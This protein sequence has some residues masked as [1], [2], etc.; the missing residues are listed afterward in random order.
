MS[1]R[2]YPMP[3]GMTPQQYGAMQI[4]PYDYVPNGLGYPE[5][6]RDSLFDPIKLLFVILRYRWLLVFA[7]LAA[8][9]GGF[10]VTMMQTPIYQA[11]ARL[12]VVSPS[13]RIFEDIELVSEAADQRA[14]LTAREKILTRALAERVVFQLG[15]TERPDF[16][17]PSPSF[18]PWNLLNRAFG[19]KDT[20][21]LDDHDAERR[22]NIAIARVLGAMSVSLIP[23]TSLLT[24]SFKDQS[25][26]YARDIANQI[27]Q[28]FIDQRVDQTGETS[29]LA[30]QFIQEQVLQVK[31]K[32]QDSEQALVD[33]AR[34]A[35]ITVTGGES[36]L[37]SSN[38][39]AI[40]TALAKAIEERLSSDLLV[41]QIDLGRGDSLEQVLGSDPLQKLR[42]EIVSLTA[43]YQQ[44]L[45][46]F[47]PGFPEMQQLQTR[48]REL[49]RQYTNGVA[50]IHDGIRM[51]REEAIGREAEL[52]TKLAEL[53]RAQ[54]EY[55]DK[56]IQYTILKRDV[57]SNR[58]QY[59]T[60]ISK[61][62]EIGVGSELKTQNAAIVDFAIRPSSPVTPRLVINLAMAFALMMALSA[63]IIYLLELLNNTFVNPD[64]VENELGLPVL[65]ILPKV[66]A[67]ALEAQ[68][69]DPKS[70][71]SEA[72]RS[73]RT[74][75]QFSG[76]EGMPRTLMVTSS[77]PSEAKSTTVHKLAMDF[78]ALGKKVLVI[79]ADLRKP[80]MHRQLGMD[81]L[82]GLSN[83][84]TN[85]LEREDMSLVMRRVREENVWVITSGT[86]P[87]NPVDLLSSTK[88]ALLID[89]VSARFDITIIDGPPVIGLSDAPILSRITQA[90]LL[91]VSTNNVSRKSAKASLKRLRSAGGNVIGA[92][93]TQFSVKAF[94]YNY[95]YRYMNYYYYQYGH[96]A[97]KL[98]GMSGSSSNAR[99]HSSLRD[100]LGDLGRDY[101]GRIV[102]RLK[103]MD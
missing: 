1:N 10:V 78:A 19:L 62:N 16:L 66:E 38:V 26:D 89:R 34:E 31:N 47:K 91:L 85:S 56:S 40:N 81:N 29:S 84:L 37:I 32:L 69:K 67:D 90:S 13:A 102:Q 25:P 99:Q 49:E 52:R 39:N 28:S 9:V 48:I 7:A 57:D 97:A 15:L 95:A 93:L 55:E 36:S 101:Y 70:G 46:T 51:K 2:A 74:S 59:D 41:K 100:R 4:P 35:G 20:A 30:R 50:I 22:Q 5:Y 64:Q 12:E 63:A 88:M 82:L 83:L 103:P 23:N 86:I 61:L 24:I 94:D 73:L 77:E 79:D 76:T 87:P 6:D 42:S 27:A 92:V 11:S 45:T 18:S 68:L 53:E 17:Y 33:Y 72:Y 8:L 58:S 65:G 60:L 44:K 96:E 80:S 43:E 21:T 71:L 54:I 75:I 98:E 14:F 3:N